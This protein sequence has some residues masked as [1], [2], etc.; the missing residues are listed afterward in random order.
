LI[1][2]S[3]PHLSPCLVKSQESGTVQKDLEIRTSTNANIP[4]NEVPSITNKIKE[5]TNISSEEQLEIYQV[6]KYENGQE[7]K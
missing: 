1:K 3:S 4:R 5:L 7:F 6:L 2:K